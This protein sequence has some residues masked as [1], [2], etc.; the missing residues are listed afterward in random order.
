MTKGTGSGR[1]SLPL[2]SDCDHVGPD[3]IEL[4]YANVI[5]LDAVGSICLVFGVNLTLFSNRK[6]TL[7]GP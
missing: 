4:S 3:F 6:I 5:G 2:F 1:S 7:S